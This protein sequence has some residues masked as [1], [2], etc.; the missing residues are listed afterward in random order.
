MK[1]FKQLNTNCGNLN[2]TKNVDYTQVIAYWF[3][4][5]YHSNQD[6]ITRVTKK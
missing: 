1:F 3:S 6:E 2:E 5:D 4:Y